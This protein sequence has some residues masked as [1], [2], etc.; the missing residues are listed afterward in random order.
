[1]LMLFRGG[2][3]VSKMKDRLR[4]YANPSNICLGLAIAAFIN[5]QFSDEKVI[6]IPAVLFFFGAIIFA[7][8]SPIE[9]KEG[10]K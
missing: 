6:A 10:K 4:K 8:Y 5:M 7:M 2:K 9:R 1:V 3:E